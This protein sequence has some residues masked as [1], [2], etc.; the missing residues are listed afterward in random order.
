VVRAD[1]QRLVSAHDNAS[2]AVVLVLQKPHVACTTFLPLAALTHKLEQ[3]GAHLEDLLL[4]LLVCFGLDLLR[5]V[6]D[7]LEVNILRLRRLVILY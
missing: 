2:F 4:Q 6:D 1:L 7:G 3:L 5:E